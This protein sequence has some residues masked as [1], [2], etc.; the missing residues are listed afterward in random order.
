[1]KPPL[2]L[3]W[4]IRVFLSSTASF[5]EIVLALLLALA[6]GICTIQLIPALFDLQVS[7]HEIDVFHDY[8]E[9]LFVLVIGVE[10]L[11]LLCKHTPGSALEIL[12]FAIARGM[13]VSHTTPMENLLVVISIGMLFAIRKFLF[14]PA[15]G[16]E[17]EVSSFDQASALAARKGSEKEGGEN[18]EAE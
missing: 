3:K 4:K 17:H 5:L 15:W 1:M 13:I 14:V 16:I 11:K 10:A 8:L 12:L 2:A 6:L 7:V 18:S 9:A